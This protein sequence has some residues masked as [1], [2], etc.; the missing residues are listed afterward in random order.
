MAQRPERKLEYARWR[1][2]RERLLRQLRPLLEP[3]IDAHG[4]IQVRM[5]QALSLHRFVGRI[6]TE[7]SDPYEC[8]QVYRI[9]WER[10]AQFIAGSF[11]V[12][13]GEDDAL[14]QP[15]APAP[16]A[17]SKVLSGVLRA[18]GHAITL[19]R[20]TRRMPKPGKP[21]RGEVQHG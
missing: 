15:E 16:D 19:E 10:A 17:Q 7:T 9:P 5:L 12:V 8:G 18:I 6:R 21:S 14:A 1:K 3:H 4:F 13:A 11:A 2:A 20:S